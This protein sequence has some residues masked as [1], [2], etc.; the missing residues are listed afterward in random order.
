MQQEK[1]EDYVIATGMQHSVRQFCEVAA[2]RLNL[3]LEWQGEREHEV[4]YSRALGQ[5]IIRVSPQYYRPAEVETLLGDPR[6]ALKQLRWLPKYTFETL[7]QEMI[8]HDL[9]EQS[10]GFG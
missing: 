10:G 8:D 4:G 9:P 1:P 5:A 3:N 2:D 7:V 6:K